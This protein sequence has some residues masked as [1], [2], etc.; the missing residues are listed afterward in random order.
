MNQSKSQENRENDGFSSSDGKFERQVESWHVKVLR[1]QIKREKG[2]RN[3]GRNPDRRQTPLTIFQKIRTVTR[4][5]RYTYSADRR[6][7][8]PSPPKKQP[9][10]SREKRWFG[11]FKCP[12]GRKW[13]S[14]YTWTIYGQ[15]QTTQC[16]KCKR[17]VLPY[18]L[19][20]LKYIILMFTLSK[21]QFFVR[22]LKTLPL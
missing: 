21:N 7:V 17:S 4:Q 18:Q 19:V 13:T 16:K 11:W 22:C 3:S 8:V 5:G 9:K 15:K 12:C 1:N 14:S 10:F 2:D 20:S 6:R